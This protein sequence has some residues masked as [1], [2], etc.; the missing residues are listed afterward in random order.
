[1]EKKQELPAETDGIRINRFWPNAD[2]AR[3]VSAM[4][5][6]KAAMYLSMERR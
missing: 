4:N 6:L 5:S 2:L 3:D 1:M